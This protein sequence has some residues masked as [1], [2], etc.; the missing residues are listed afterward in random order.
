MTVN[1]T[2]KEMFEELGYKQDVYTYQIMY[3]NQISLTNVRIVNFDMQRKIVL[4][5]NCDLNPIGFDVEIH[6]AIHKQLL[7][8]GWL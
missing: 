6:K 2:A 5:Y 8:L 1:K 3:R 4:S 7:E